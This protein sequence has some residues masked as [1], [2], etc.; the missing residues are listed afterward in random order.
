MLRRCCTVS[1]LSNDD[2]NEDSDKMTGSIENR[3]ECIMCSG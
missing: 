1:W 2:G 3:E